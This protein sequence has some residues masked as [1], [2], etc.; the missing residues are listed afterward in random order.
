MGDPV[1]A[2]G[3]AKQFEPILI[4]HPSEQFFPINPK[5]Y[6]ER[7]SLWR[8]APPYADRNNWG[9]PPRTIFPR[10]PAVDRNNLAALQSEAV[11]KTWI[12]EPSLDFGVA[13]AVE[14]Q[15][16][17]GDEHFLDFGG[18][19]PPLAPGSEVTLTSMNRYAALAASEYAGP[20]TDSRPWYYVEFLSN[21]DLSAFTLNRKPNGLDLFKSVATNSRLS[22]PQALVYH[23]FYPVHQ[24]ALDGC[25]ETGE[26]AKFA[27]F[28]G[29][30]GSM[31]ILLNSANRPQYIGL[32]SR[33][34]GDPSIV[35]EEEQRVGMSIFPWSMVQTV[36]T[37]SGD[38][39]KLY[40]SNGTHGYYLSPGPHTVIGFTPG[41]DSSGRSCGQVETL[42]DAISSE[43]VLSPG[44]PGKDSSVVL[45]VLKCISVILAWWAAIE[46]SSD[47]LPTPETL[48][49]PTQPTDQTA[50]P[51]PGGPGFGKIIRPD[52]LSFLEASQA[53]TL[54][55]WNVN[56]YTAADKRAY[57][58]AIDRNVQVWWNPRTETAGYGGRWGPRVEHDPFSRRCGMKCPDFLTMFLE[59]IAVLMNK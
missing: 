2:R 46:I 17:P 16:P 10:L 22:L 56:P 30:W 25:E 23:F 27:S 47:R 24:E 31:A 55:D 33:N 41:Y 53:A 14:G 19:E 36:T 54:V 20:L 32:T 35:G 42:D 57:D 9:E 37:S 40:V 44:D 59:G 11:G 50:G 39:P 45:I 43:Q 7:S 8:A 3:F 18:W 38:H 51:L 4:F 29:A 49:M 58:L 28:A 52:G 13:K 15:H 34:V 26:A 5:W 6:L 48:A 21:A 12:G 1:V